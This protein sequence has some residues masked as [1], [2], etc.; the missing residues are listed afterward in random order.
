MLRIRSSIVGVLLLSG[1]TEGKHLPPPPNVDLAEVLKAGMR[2]KEVEA[3]LGAPSSNRLLENT[4]PAIREYRYD[5]WGLSLGFYTDGLGDVRISRPWPH[6]VVG[7]K[8]GDPLDQ[9]KDKLATGAEGLIR[10]MRTE[11]WKSAICEAHQ[12]AS[13][14][15]LVYE[16]RLVDS[17]IK[18]MWVPK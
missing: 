8:I 18:G 9:V 2:E 1:C 5:D 3:I 10:D 14:Q 15:P 4:S 12:E 7:V 17:D 6:A 13:S 11:R 16:I